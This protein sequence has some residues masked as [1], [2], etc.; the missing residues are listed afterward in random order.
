VRTQ[1]ALTWAAATLAAAA[2]AVA[3]ASAPRGVPRSLEAVYAG[4]GGRFKCFDGSGA[5]DVARIND[6][7]CD[8]AD[9][10]DEPGTSAC[11]NGRFYCRNKG[12]R[13]KFVSSHLVN[14][15][16]CDCCDGADEWASKA[17]CV[18]TCQEDGAAWR[19]AQAEAVRKAEAGARARLEYA[20]QG[21]AAA[22]ERQEK[23]A[24]LTASYDKAKAAREA[25]EKVRL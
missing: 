8:C 2:A 17:G 11:P 5:I 22:T 15:G 21:R 9:G 18:D 3:G 23:L 19:L 6:D 16:V 13:G 7:F 20:S 24:T 10:S 14:D 4:A 25:A 1:V 12:S